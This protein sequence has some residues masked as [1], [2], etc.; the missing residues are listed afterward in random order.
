MSNRNE[1]KLSCTKQK[2]VHV[3]HKLLLVP[4]QRNDRKS[5]V[6]Y[7]AT[8][9]YVACLLPTRNSIQKEKYT[10]GSYYEIDFHQH[11]Y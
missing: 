11:M 4:R 1:M 5:H 10:L 6:Y 2:V 8:C 7:S 3:Q 9:L